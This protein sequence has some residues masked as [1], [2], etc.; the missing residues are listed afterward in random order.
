MGP[1]PTARLAG[2]SAVEHGLRGRRRQFGRHSGRHSGTGGGAGGAGE[3]DAAELALMGS[4]F[5]LLISSLPLSV[6]GQ[7]LHLF[8]SEH[9]GMLIRVDKR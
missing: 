6:S 2:Y 3:A 8:Y 5:S 1:E 4:P 9:L 7:L